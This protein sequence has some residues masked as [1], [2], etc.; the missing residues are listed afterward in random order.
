MLEAK[1][2]YCLGLQ[3]AQRPW[4]QIRCHQ[5]RFDRS[6]IY[7]KLTRITA[8]ARRLPMGRYSGPE[9][10]ILVDQ[11]TADNFLK[12]QL[13]PTAF[14]AAANGNSKINLQHRMQVTETPAWL[15]KVS[16]HGHQPCR[17]LYSAWCCV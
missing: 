2:Q 11:G 6:G 8:E 3:L 9:R 1:F 13:D 10:D 4:N 16:S 5:I 14:K 12:E 7:Q 17:P 15:A